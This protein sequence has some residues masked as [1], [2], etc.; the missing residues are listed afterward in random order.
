VTSV[1]TASCVL[2]FTELRALPNKQSRL[3]CGLLKASHDGRKRCNSALWAGSDSLDE[4]RDDLL[5]NAAMTLPIKEARQADRQVL[6]TVTATV[7]N[8]GKI[9]G[10]EMLQY[11]V[12]NLG[13]SLEQPV[14]SLECFQG[15][16]LRPG[17]SKQVTFTL[18]FLRFPSRTM[19]AMR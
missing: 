6:F 11:S 10:T 5:L 2:R 3:L 19:R 8:T 18:G 16:A 12:R 13:A 9:A 7:R 4:L 1:L 15:V 14:R 17:E